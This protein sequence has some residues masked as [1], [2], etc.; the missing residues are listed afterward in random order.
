MSVAS[1]VLMVRNAVLIYLVGTV[2][3][4]A[5]FI[6]YL[7]SI[8]ASQPQLQYYLNRLTSSLY[9]FTAA[10]AVIIAVT[11]SLEY[12]G[13]RR[14]ANLRDIYM[15]GSYGAILQLLSI[16]FSVVGIVYE[17]R[18]LESSYTSGVPGFMVMQ[19][20]A[21]LV[22]AS[23]LAFSVIGSVINLA[24]WLLVFAVTYKLGSDYGNGLVKVG[25]LA[26][27]VGLILAVVSM[28]Y[29]FVIYGSP[30]SPPVTPVLLAA[31][32]IILGGL[33]TLIGIVVLLVGLTN[34]AKAPLI[35][36]E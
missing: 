16:P 27:M 20:P 6:G 12:V 30:G 5:L 21:P 7:V 22:R 3:L 19:T 11:A 35:K 1:G 34:L 15:L 4:V 28:S 9:A 13:F 10:N 25:S 32:V 36:G 29:I 17:V 2:V 33:L 23:A 31:G 14:L 24:G 26:T 8:T 18:E